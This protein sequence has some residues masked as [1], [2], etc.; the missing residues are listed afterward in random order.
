MF[1]YANFQNPTALD[2]T[3]SFIF[4]RVKSKVYS[5]YNY[6]L[7]WHE[8]VGLI[9]NNLI[10]FPISSGCVY[11]LDYLFRFEEFEKEN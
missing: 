3:I 1:Y 9:P 5:K 10:F 8:S 11:E 4:S 7:E 2:F 6:I